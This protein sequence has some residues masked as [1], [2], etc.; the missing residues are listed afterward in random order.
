MADDKGLTPTEL[1]MECMDEIANP[2]DGYGTVD[3]ILI[4]MHHT[5]DTMGDSGIEW[6][7]NIGL[8]HEQLG[9]V[10]FVRTLIKEN[11]RK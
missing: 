10:E 3:K 11:L 6:H 7:S 8:I 9:L 4:I 2:T 1:L 5:K